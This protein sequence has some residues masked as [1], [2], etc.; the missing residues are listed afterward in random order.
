MFKFVSNMNNCFVEQREVLKEAVIVLEKMNLGF[1]EKWF[2]TVLL[3]SNFDRGRK[4]N[5]QTNMN[6]KKR[7]GLQMMISPS[8]PR[9][10]IVLL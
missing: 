4:T 3:F 8:L 1:E 2:Q 10:K 7:F 9:L 5:K 6:S